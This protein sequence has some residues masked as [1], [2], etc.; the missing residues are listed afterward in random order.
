M[1]TRV[2]WI[3]ASVTL[4]G[5]IVHP[6]KPPVH[7]RRIEMGST[8]YQREEHSFSTRLLRRT[9]SKGCQHLPQ[10]VIQSMRDP[11]FRRSHQNLPH[12][13]I[14]EPPNPPWVLPSSEGFFLPK[15]SA[16]FPVKN[17]RVSMSTIMGPVSYESDTSVDNEPYLQSYG[18]FGKPRHHITHNSSFLPLCA[19]VLIFIVLPFYAF[20]IFLNHLFFSWW[21]TYFAHGQR[22][23]RWPVNVST[24]K[25]R[26]LRK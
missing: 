26:G 12:D 25:Q 24:C 1:D 18:R 16:T 14:S 6:G 20:S 13:A 17:G 19:D 10:A 9:P 23:T 8:P 11:A 5:G 3:S 2:D 21:N 15:I 22:T 7:T 4:D